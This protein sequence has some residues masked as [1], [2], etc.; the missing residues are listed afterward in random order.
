MSKNGKN[1]D[2]KNIDR[3]QIAQL[4]EHFKR[5][6]SGEV[7]PAPTAKP[8][9]FTWGFTPEERERLERDRKPAPPKNKP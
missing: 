2:P 9:S 7:K 3:D 6:A 1:T 5:V 4:G 8:P